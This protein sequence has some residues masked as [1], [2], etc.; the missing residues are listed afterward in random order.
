MMVSNGLSAR[1]GPLRRPKVCLT[2]PN[3]GRCEPPPPPPGPASCS[4]LPLTQE[5]ELGE[6]GGFETTHC[7]PS[8]A[9]FI[10]IDIQGHADVGD[11]TIDDG[12]SNCVDGTAQYETDIAGIFIC[13]MTVTW[14][15]SS[16][17]VAEA[18]IVVTEEEPP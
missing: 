14:P 3:P 11:F 1:R 18:T 15:D 5:I 16:F 10:E 4:L 12:G 17:C 9:Q 13:T 8:F 7:N 6:L 2:H